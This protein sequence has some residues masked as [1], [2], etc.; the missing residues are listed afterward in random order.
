DLSKDD[1]PTTPFL[2]KLFYRTGSFHRPEEFTSP[3]LPLHIHIYTWKTC[4]LT[5]LAH[6]LA[7][8]V[9]Q[10]PILPSPAIGTRLVFRLIFADTRGGPPRY[11]AKDLGSVVI[12]GGGPG[13]ADDNDED[14]SDDAVGS[15]DDGAKTLNDVKF[16]VGDCVSCAILP[17]SE[18]TG[19]VV[20]ASARWDHDGG[21]HGGG[22]RTGGGRT[23]GRDVYPRG[24]GGGG[25]RYADRDRR[26]GRDNV[27]DGEWRRG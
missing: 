5:E 9:T 6:H 17:P 8:A 10:P 3:S 24:G 26:G 19:E 20:S 7:A 2:L 25:G 22:G 15:S 12:G 11:V 18:V 4:T 23:R 16:V 21:W 27:P 1:E 14:D 13:A